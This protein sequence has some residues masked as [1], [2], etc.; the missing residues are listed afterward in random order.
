MILFSRGGQTNYLCISSMRTRNPPLPSFVP[1]SK[2]TMILFRWRA[3]AVKCPEPHSHE[4][5][6]NMC[7]MNLNSKPALKTLGVS[8]CRGKLS[9]IMKKRRNERLRTLRV[10]GRKTRSRYSIGEV[11][12]HKEVALRTLKAKC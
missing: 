3:V 10:S 9:K 12:A 5:L 6:T 11:K 7:R 2:R 4:S 1:L 8:H